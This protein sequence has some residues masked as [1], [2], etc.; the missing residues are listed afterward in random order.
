M[1]RNNLFRSLIAVF[2]LLWAAYS[3][4]PSFEL[5]QQ[6]SVADKYFAEL[7]DYTGFTRDDINE[8]LNAADLQLR[9]QELGLSQDSLQQVKSTAEKLAAIYPDM[10]R[11]EE[12]AIKLGL[13]LL[14]GTYLVYE[15]DLPKL[16]ETNAKLRDATLDSMIAQARTLS[17]RTGDDYF[18][19]LNGLFQQRGV[20]M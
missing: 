9:L 3:L 4:Y 15:V 20:S 14:G 18:V 6:R 2:L 1:R 17:L 19:V 13:D 5:M 7:M 16:V 12:K 10:S 8:A 11:N